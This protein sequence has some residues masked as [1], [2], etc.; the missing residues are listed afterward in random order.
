M[1]VEPPPV[2][3]LLDTGDA[4]YRSAFMVSPETITITELATG[5]YLDVNDAFETLFGLAR[6]EVIGRHASEFG[7]WADPAERAELVA[8]I[9]RDGTVRDFYAVGRHRDG[10]LRTCSINATVVTHDGQARLVLAVR[11][12]TP[13]VRTE[14]ALRE[15]LERFSKAFH[16]FPSAVLL[17]ELESGRL[18]E[19]NDVL[20]RLSGY[21]REELEGRGVIEVGLYADPADRTVLLSH[22]RAEGRATKLELPL[23]RKDGA[24]L[25]VLLTS[26]LVELA[27]VPH[28]LSVLED[29]TAQRRAE[30]EKASLE[31]QLRGAQKLEALGTLAGGIAHDFNNILTALMAFTELAKLDI[32][33]PQAALSDLEEVRRASVRAQDLVRRILTFSRRQKQERKLVDVQTVVRDAVAL[34]RPTLPSTIEIVERYLSAPQNVLADTGQIHQ[35]VMN[36]GAN[37]A[38]AMRDTGGTLSIEVREAAAAAV[39]SIC[40]VVRDTGCGMSSAVQERLFEP[41]FTTK[42]LGEGTGLGLSVVHGIVREHDGRIEV[43]SEPGSGTELRILLP[44][45]HDAAH[46]EPIPVAEILRGGG[47]RVLFVDDEPAICDLARRLLTRLG[48][49]VTTCCSPVE[50]LAFFTGGREEFDVVLTDLTMP[51]MT[52]IEV[53][54]RLHARNPRL[55]ILLMTGF[56]G[57]WTQE[58]VRERGVRELL[59]KPFTLDTLARAL[60][61]ALEDRARGGAVSGP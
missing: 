27:G 9:Q 44:V 23:R 25:T 48:Y 45:Q 38:Y 33:E 3:P 51:Q 36:L 32:E 34:L 14:R 54:T 56:S 19:F 17:V 28:V 11:D 4:I 5:R 50:A 41:F 58:R 7:I 16:A 31:E 13:Q 42:P 35:V 21:A 49:R 39:P 46:A 6:R 40:I 10:T 29:L 60:R 53:A 8:R 43:Q 18:V 37:A 59:P 24:I 15:A 20:P 26:E 2:V 1:S 55:P 30:R 12:I 57:D 22:L 47:E 61:S 52:G